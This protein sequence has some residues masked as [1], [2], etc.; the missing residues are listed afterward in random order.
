M[1]AAPDS[2]EG[3]VIGARWRVGP[4][5]GKGGMGSVHRGEHVGTERAVAIK[6][7]HAR[8]AQQEEFRRRFEREARAASKLS[9]PA[10][11]SVLDFGEHEGRL[12]LV[13]EHAAGHP[14]D[15]RIAQGPLPPRDAVAIARGVAIALRHAHSIGIV[16]RDLKPAN[17]M[18]LDHDQSGV[19]CKLLDFGGA[20]SI[21]PNPREQVTGLGMVFCSP[22]YLSPEQALG[23]H[24]DG[25][26]DLYALG[27]LLWEM[28]AGRRP[29]VDEDVLKVLRAHIHE[30][31]PLVRSAA[32]QVSPELEALVAKLLEKLPS[33]R[34][35]TGDELLAAL[36][37][38]PE[39]RRLT[40]PS[41][42]EPAPAPA[43]AAARTRF[44][45]GTLIL[46]ALLVAALV[47]ALAWVL[48]RH[49]R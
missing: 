32:P 38:V 1:S 45:F 33:L 39:G 30:P 35:Q 22:S 34:F 44:G 27:I 17:V 11:V 14:L 2:L 12:F 46:I 47:G 42:A 3:Q 36:D 9:H 8:F 26:S 29:F 15:E 16:H 43:E 28:L 49:A 7:L 24:A 20:K 5:I 13:M 31:A 6:V 40:Q 23:G 4:I 19:I 25:R 21:S 18:L 10:C 37:E 48:G 41:A